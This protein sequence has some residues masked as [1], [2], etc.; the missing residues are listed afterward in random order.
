MKFGGGVGCGRGIRSF[1]SQIR[2][3]RYFYSRFVL[4][5]ALKLLHCTTPHRTAPHPAQRTS[6]G[7]SC[8]VPRPPLSHVS[9]SLPSHATN[10]CVFGSPCPPMLA[11]SVA[12]AAAGEPMARRG[13][14]NGK[15]VQ[16]LWQWRACFPPKN[17]YAQPC[18]QKTIV[19]PFGARARARAHCPSTPSEHCHRGEQVGR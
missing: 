14:W 18:K 13:L 5:N 8:C 11:P 2:P 19:S 4:C 16:H 12:Q 7:G 9:L 10:L 6:E 17:K 1:A 15:F 3:R